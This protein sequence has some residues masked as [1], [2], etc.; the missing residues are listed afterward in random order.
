MPD[1]GASVGLFSA[2]GIGQDLRVTGRAIVAAMNYCGATRPCSP[3]KA[4]VL[5]QLS[6]AHN[7]AATGWS[8]GGVWTQG[9]SGLGKLT[10]RDGNPK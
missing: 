9:V 8:G 10:G 6:S 7:D 1:R 3:P 2:E 5:F 4:G